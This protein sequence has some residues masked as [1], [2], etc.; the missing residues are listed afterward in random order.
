MM[1]HKNT[2]TE[3]HHISEGYCSS[4]TAKG[5]QPYF[6]ESFQKQ[7]SWLSSELHNLLESTFLEGS[8]ATSVFKYTDTEKQQG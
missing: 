1:K 4:F 5:R 8:W 3:L 6:D 7:R 2:R